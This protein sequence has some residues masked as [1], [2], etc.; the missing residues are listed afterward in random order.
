MKRILD[1]LVNYFGLDEDERPTYQRYFCYHVVAGT[2]PTV[3]SGVATITVLAIYKEDERCTYCQNLHMVNAGGPEAA[4]AK[5]IRYL[6]SYH[7]NGHL[8]KVQSD[9]RGLD[10]DPTVG[11]YPLVRPAAFREPSLQGHSPQ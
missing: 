9:I 3:G 5:A 6:D 10:D 8:R 11:M 7:E 2:G 4:M 1:C